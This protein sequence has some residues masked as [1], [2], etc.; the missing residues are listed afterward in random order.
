[1]RV[2]MHISMSLCEVESH[3]RFYKGEFLVS[4]MHHDWIPDIEWTNGL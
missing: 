1:M 4:F 2:A 3:E